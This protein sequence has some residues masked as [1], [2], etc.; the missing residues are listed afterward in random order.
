Q[1]I[2]SADRGELVGHDQVMQEMDALIEQKA[3]NK[4]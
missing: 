4:A 1:G 2:E 3:T